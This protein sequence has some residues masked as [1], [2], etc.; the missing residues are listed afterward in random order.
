M[1]IFVSRFW[2]TYIFLTATKTIDFLDILYSHVS[3]RHTL[4]LDT[5]LASMDKLYNQHRDLGIV[6]INCHEQMTKL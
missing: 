4:S 6:L 2:E 3:K 1:I 5:I